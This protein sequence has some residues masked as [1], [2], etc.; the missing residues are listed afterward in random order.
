VKL[1]VVKGYLIGRKIE[2]NLRAAGE[3]TKQDLPLY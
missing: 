1:I 3:N 2:G